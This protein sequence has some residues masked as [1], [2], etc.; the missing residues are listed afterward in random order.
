MGVAGVPCRV[1]ATLAARGFGLC[2]RE[3]WEGVPRRAQR[4]RRCR[5]PASAHPRQQL[6]VQ[7]LRHLLAPT[8]Q[9]SEVV[10]ARPEPV[11]V[12][13]SAAPCLFTSVTTCVTACRLVPTKGSACEAASASTL[14]VWRCAL[15]LVVMCWCGS[16]WV[17]R[18]LFACPALRVE[19]L[20]DRAATGHTGSRQCAESLLTAQP[21]VFCP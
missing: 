3:A 13:G 7:G 18:S 19:I 21:S 11:K 6:G 8:V 4:T 20:K 5:P 17:G 9:G 14:V 12:N 16:V 1:L 2:Q 15:A 10:T